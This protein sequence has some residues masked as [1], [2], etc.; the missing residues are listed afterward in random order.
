[1]FYLLLSLLAPKVFAFGEGLNFEVMRP[2]T[3]YFN[4]VKRQE[5]MRSIYFQGGETFTADMTVKWDI[6]WCGFQVGLKKDENIELSK[7]LVL[8]PLSFQKDQNQ[9]DHTTYTW[10][11]VA[12]SGQ[13]A[14]EYKDFIPFLFQCSLGRGLTMSQGVFETI[15]GKYIKAVKKAEETEGKDGASKNKGQ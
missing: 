11:F 6:P 3:I 8:T 2:M 4:Q 5:G 7:G 15:V 1:M 10:S 9:K 12:A 13:K 14:P